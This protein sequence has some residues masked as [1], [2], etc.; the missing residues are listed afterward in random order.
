[1]V[2]SGTAAV[3][4]PVLPPELVALPVPWVLPVPGEPP[5]L[6]VLPPVPPIGSL[7]ES[8]HAEIIDASD[9][10][11][12]PAAIRYPVPLRII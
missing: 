2:L 3:L 9:T 12:S 1:L 6:L 4:V 7:I 8:L 11:M 10:D 5:L